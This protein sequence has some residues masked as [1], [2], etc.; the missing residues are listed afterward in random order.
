MADGDNTLT[1]AWFAEAVEAL[2]P[3][4]Y[5]AAM[6]LCRNP[7]D[8]QDLVADSVARAW[9]H[10]AGLRD[11]A[12]FRGWLFTILT[13]GFRSR[14][15]GQAVRG[16]DVPLDDEPSG[17]SF[18]LFEKLHRPIL[19]WWDNPERAFLDKLI[20]EDF[21]RAIDALP[22]PLRV[23]VVLAHLEGFKYHE[24]AE[25][26]AIPIGTV[27]S[28]LGRAR[29]RLQRALWDHAVDAGLVPGDAP[30]RTAP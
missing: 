9:M 17:D 16:V 3:D 25:Q 26:L 6:R 29:A 28:R 13:N 23:V 20:Q 18:S 1:G 19:L 7:A 30:E 21:A 15:R 2:L 5:G 14:C 11:R 4:L 8:A 10:R 22:E 27:R 24:I 12:T